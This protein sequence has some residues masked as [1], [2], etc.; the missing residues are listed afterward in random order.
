M[1]CPL[2]SPARMTRARSFCLDFEGQ[3]AVPSGKSL[4]V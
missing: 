1:F 4:P 2:F 3:D